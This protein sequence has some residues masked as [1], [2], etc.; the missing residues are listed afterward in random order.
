M[1]VLSAQP[2]SQTASRTPSVDILRGAAI[3]FMALDHVRDFM[4]N[5]RVSPENIEKTFPALFFTRWV[6]H[7]CAPLFFF[8]AGVGMYLMLS[9]SGSIQKVAHFL[10]TRGL[11]LMVLEF[12]LIWFAWTFTLPGHL[13]GVI[14]TLGLSMIV[15]SL[16]I[17][18]PLRYV[19]ILSLI[20]IA[21]HDLF[22]GVLPKQFGAYGWLWALLHRHASINVPVINWWV[23]VLFPLI[24][25]AAVMSAGFSFGPI[26]E[27]SSP[28]RE[29]A[30]LWIGA[31]A[32]V[33]FVVLRGF[34]LYGNPSAAFA[35]TSPGP[36]AVQP[37][38]VMSLVSFL[39]VEKYPSSLQFLLMTLGPALVIM[40]WL[41][42]RADR[43]IPAILRPLLVYGRVPL[44]F[45]VCHLFLIH[46]AAIGVYASLHEP[47]GWLLHGGFF[48][49]EPPNPGGVDLPYIWA[50]WIA[51]VALLYYPCRWFAAVKQRRTEWWLAYL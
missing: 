20:V 39:D 18:L 47:V 12:T 13:A 19:A 40:A 31:G 3:V 6:T 32:T 9:R 10:W 25:L 51:I 38:F 5:I 21:G 33:L 14:W 36:W 8:L 34:N 43:G 2:P 46:V 27:W 17:R 7:Y 26:L 28:K 30:I 29:R 48:A 15:L 35:S 41:E 23:F 22:D 42:R 1:T 44:F 4:S 16:V 50:W 49:N 45:Y 37:T 24:P 11:W